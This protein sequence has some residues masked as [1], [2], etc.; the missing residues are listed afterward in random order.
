MIGKG[1]AFFPLELPVRVVVHTD[2]PFKLYAGSEEGPERIL[3]PSKSTARLMGL[4]WPGGGLHLVVPEETMWSVETTEIPPSGEVPDPVPMEVPVEFE[5]RDLRDEVMNYVREVLSQQMADDGMESLEEAND[6]EMDDEDDHLIVSP[7]EYEELDS[8]NSL[9]N[10]DLERDNVSRGTTDEE[11]HDETM[12]S[13]NPGEDGEG[14]PGGP[15]H[16]PAEDV[17]QPGEGAHR[18]G[19]GGE[20]DVRAGG[21]DAP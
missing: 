1:Q 3:G 17:H 20:R 18:G 13:A 2:G 16:A 6:F 10:R 7:Y 4:N 15:V 12:Q 14:R 11:H 8:D 9:E 21:K 5:A 19:P